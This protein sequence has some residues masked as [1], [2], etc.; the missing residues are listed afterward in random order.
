MPEARIPGRTDTGILRFLGTLTLG[1]ALAC[2]GNQKPSGDSGQ[3]ATGASATEPPALAS[4]VPD[5]GRAGIDYPV[6]IVLEGSGFAATG[7]IVT[8]AGIRSDP[9]ESTHD[10]TRIT[11]LIPKEKPTVGEV[12][13]EELLPGEYPVTVTTPGGTSRALLFTLTGGV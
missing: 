13:P 1:F 4:L 6:R 5:R 3:A 2:A 8:F 10:G 11:Y 12:P 7:N 9:L